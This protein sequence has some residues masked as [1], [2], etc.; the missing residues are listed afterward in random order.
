MFSDLAEFS[1]KRTPLATA[2]ATAR[3]EGVVGEAFIKF[4]EGV[5]RGFSTSTP[6]SLSN[7]FMQ[8]LDYLSY[9]HNIIIAEYLGLYS[10]K[11]YKKH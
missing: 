5:W 2:K 3:D 11:L 7:V 1:A 8:S 10:G 6:P 4:G 9:S